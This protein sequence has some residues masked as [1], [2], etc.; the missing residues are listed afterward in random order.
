MF[1]VNAIWIILMLVDCA[2]LSGLKRRY[3]CFSLL[4]FTKNVFMDF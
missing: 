2:E 3:H 1:E 4:N